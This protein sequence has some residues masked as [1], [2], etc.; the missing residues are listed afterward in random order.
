MLLI[1]AVSAPVITPL[2]AIKIVVP[3]QYKDQIEAIKEAE[4]YEREQNLQVENKSANIELTVSNDL[5]IVADFLK[6]EGLSKKEINDYYR[7]QSIDPHY[8]E[9]DDLLKVEA[10]EDQSP[11]VNADEFLV[12]SVIEAT[13]S[14][15]E[16]ELNLAAGEGIISG[17]IIDK[18]SGQPL[19]GVA[20]LLEDTNIATVTDSEG[21]YSIGPAPAGEYTVSFVKTGYIEANVT[22]YVIVGGEV[23]AFPFGLPPRPADMSDEVYELQD[24]TV[25]A[26]EANNIMLQLELTM[27]SDSI[28]SVMS[29]EDFSKF[30]ASDIGDAVKRVSGVSVVGGKY[31]VIRGLGDRYVWTTMNGLPIASPDPDKLAVQLDLFPSSLF[32][33]IA[34]SKTFTPDQSATATG[35]ID[36]KLKSLPDEFFMNVSTSVGFHSIATGN[37]KFLVNDRGGPM[38]QF[39]MGAENRGLP[40]GGRKFPEDL[41]LPVNVLPFPIPGTITQAEKDAAVAEAVAITDLIGRDFHNY[42]DAPGPDYGVKFSFGNAY[43]VNDRIR[44]GYFGGVNYSRKFRMVEEADYFRSATDTSGTNTLGPENFVDSDV[45]IGY[46]NQLRTEATATSVLSWLVGFGLEVGEDHQFS[47]SRLDLRQ[48]ENENARLIG[49]VYN[50]FPFSSDSDSLDTEIAETLRYTERRLISDQAA[51]AHRFDLPDVVFDE[52]EIEWAVGRDTA[53]QEEPGY[54]Q[55]RTIVLDNGD[56]TLAQ[57][58]TAAGSASPSFVIWREI[59]EERDNQ[60]IDFSFKDTFADG[61][62]TKIK[63]GTLTSRGDRK[64]FDEYISLK[65][66]DLSASG[67]TTVDASDDPDAPLKNFNELDA[68]GYTIAADVSLETEQDGRYFMV[69]QQLFEKFRVIGGY[70]HEKNSADVQVNGELQLRGAG[71]NNPLKDL[72]TSGGYEDDRWLPGLTF[73]YQPTDRVSLKLAYSKTLALPSAREVSPYASSAFSGSDIDVGNPDLSPSDVENFDIGFSWFNESSDSF[74]VTLFHKVVD[75]RIE[76]LSGIGADTFKDVTD[77]EEDTID[78]LNYSHYQILTF[79]DN[80][81]AALYSWYNNPNEATLTGIEVEGRKSLGFLH[82]SLRDFS[83]GGNYT[84]IKGE[85]DRFPIEIAAKSFVGRPIEETRALTNQP[86]YIFNADLTYDNPDWGLRVSLISYHISEVLQGV[87][88]ADSY[89]VYGNAYKSLDL[90]ASKTIKENLKVSFSIKNITDSE[91]GTYYDVEGDDVD[92]DAYKVGQSVSLGINYEF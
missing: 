31:A 21:R 54:V 50:Q 20:I 25:T 35:A 86:E 39:A 71:S 79:S 23:S 33:S 27:N 78:P 74:G 48:S 51:G 49:D 52:L 92:R 68:A 29:S 62:D 91:R 57:D 88:F 64:V 4:R 14:A 18:E 28:L 46:R 7:S 85:V 90:T 10:E 87:S 6:S 53:T 11:F 73:I 82:D 70:R 44:A 26:E 83:L 32:E 65:G 8:A 77:I 16:F 34:V 55:T 89:D 59:E 80:L 3:D 69:E 45:A 63:F 13:D 81:D 19:S 2:S 1:A 42:G 66:D 17:Q 67:D 22:D 37:D 72:P 15:T 84:Y 47:L 58:S 5:D 76:K 9:T 56:L 40:D 36:L 30:A 41:N 24:F 61:F 75:N 60:R 38:D 43:D 12:Q